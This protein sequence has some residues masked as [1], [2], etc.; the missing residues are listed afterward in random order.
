MM[1]LLLLTSCRR[2]EHAI[3]RCAKF[4]FKILSYWGKIQKTLRGVTFFDSHCIVMGRCRFLKSISVFGFCRFFF[5]QILGSWCRFFKILL[6][7]FGFWYFVHFVLLFILLPYTLQ[8]LHR[9]QNLKMTNLMTF[10]HFLFYIEHL[11][12]C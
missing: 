8:G 11:C 9:Q 1:L 2:Y 5:K 6:Y 3:N 12:P 10:M 7:L 4:C